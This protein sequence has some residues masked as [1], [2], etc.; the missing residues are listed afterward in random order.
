MAKTQDLVVKMTINSN[1]FARGL[2][3]AKASMNR[4]NGEVGM[5]SK[6][7]KTAISGM[8]KAFGALGIAVGGAQLFKSFISSTQTMGDAW[9][10]TMVA[11]KTSFQVFATAVASGTGTILSNF[12]ESIRAARE[13]AEAMD[14][15]ESAQIS[16]KYA[17]TKFVPAF[18]EAMTRYREAK[19]NN[20]KT[21]MAYALNDMQTNFNAYSENAFNQRASARNTVLSALDTYTNG[22]VNSGNLDKY[23]DQ[24]YLEIVNGVFP[25][26]LQDFNN[27]ETERKKGDYFFNQAKDEMEKKYGP[28]WRREAEAM[29]M[30]SEINDDTLKEMLSVLES[31]ATVRNEINSMRRQMNRVVKGETTTTTSPTVTTPSGG[32]AAPSM[33]PDQVARY[34]FNDRTPAP[35]IDIP[36][37]D[38]EIVEPE[39]DALMEA[40]AAAQERMKQLAAE[41]Q[42]AFTAANALAGAFGAFGDMS[43]STLGKVA[44]G[45]GNVIGQIIATVQAMMS[46]AGAEVVEGVVDVF[47]NENGD[48][49][50][51]LAV[52][53]VALA[54]ILGIVA[55]AKSAFAGSFAEGGIVGG[56]SYTGDRLWA[57][58]NSGEMILNQQQQ[59]SLL[60]NSGGQVRFVIEGSQLKG[61]LE[62]YETIQ[63]L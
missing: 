44:K 18:N 46:L 34:W 16:G 3:N 13:F 62:N 28:G 15:F 23:L 21:G 25:P 50:K 1:D 31:Y 26:I 43:D 59:A 22:F 40:V 2:T 20:D 36:V 9:N 37:E 32:T 19:A 39:L 14:A 49:W 48:V 4:F 17:K 51:K 27:L 42:L 33:T 54:G 30:L 57:R 7:F 10:N 58:V 29:K 35:L 11:A 45:L 8:T 12:R 52:S 63:N 41:T 24:L 60:S 6:A 47:A 55:S 53:A 5:A 56:S 38:E 61:V